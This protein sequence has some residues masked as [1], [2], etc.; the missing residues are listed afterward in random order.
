MIYEFVEKNV[1]V[2]KFLAVSSLVWEAVEK[3]SFKESK[4]MERNPNWAELEQNW[5]NCL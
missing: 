2:G 1:G 5:S 4:K 3:N